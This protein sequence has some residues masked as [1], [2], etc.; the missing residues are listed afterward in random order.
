MIVNTTC[1]IQFNSINHVTIGSLRYFWTIWRAWNC[2]CIR[3]IFVIA[4]LIFVYWSSNNI[5]SMWNG[6]VSMKVL[7]QRRYTNNSCPRPT[8][9]QKMGLCICE[10]ILFRCIWR[11][12]ERRER[13]KSL[14]YQ[15]LWTKAQIYSNWIT[16]SSVFNEPKWK[17]NKQTNTHDRNCYAV[18]VVLNLWPHSEYVA[19][20]WNWNETRRKPEVACNKMTNHINCTSN[21]WNKWS[22]NKKAF[23]GVWH[24]LPCVKW[25]FICLSRHTVCHTFHIQFRV[26]DV[27]IGGFREAWHRDVSYKNRMKITKCVT[28]A[29]E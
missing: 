12:N 24:N 29:M 8:L 4:D 26:A 20:E 27:V 25:F 13:Q 23:G 9:A 6:K 14:T 7:L 28:N 22:K 15:N 19:A 17:K 5:S 18:V 11:V 2:Y 16:N 21:K 1:F 10:F 3:S